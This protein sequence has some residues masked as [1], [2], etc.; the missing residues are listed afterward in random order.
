MLAGVGGTFFLVS[1]GPGLQEPHANTFVAQAKVA[2]RWLA[3][4]LWT[5]W[6]HW[7]EPMEPNRSKSV[8]LAERAV[9]LDP[10]DAG[11]RWVLGH[12]LAFERRWPESD[13]A[14]EAAFRLDANLADGWAMQG[15]TR[16]A[17][18]G[19]QRGGRRR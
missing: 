4:N 18:A 2:H 13:A 17:G 14:F 10:N 11:C 7:G 6:A 16:K 1:L 12:V 8:A 9:V 3:F 15:D 19:L 5:S